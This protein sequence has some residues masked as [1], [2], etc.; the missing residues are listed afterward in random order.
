MIVET[1]LEFKKTL[2]NYRNL[3]GEKN[4][5]NMLLEEKQQILERYQVIACEILLK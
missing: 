4:S 2:E 1:E 3:E 5:L